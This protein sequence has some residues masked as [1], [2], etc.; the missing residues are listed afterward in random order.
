M[1]AVKD[2]YYGSSR[3]PRGKGLR[4]GA[5]A[6][7]VVGRGRAAAGHGQ[8]EGNGAETGLIRLLALLL[9][10]AVQALSALD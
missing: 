5:G 6:V 2:A 7:A 9:Y 1:K 4:S 10:F 3:F 8:N